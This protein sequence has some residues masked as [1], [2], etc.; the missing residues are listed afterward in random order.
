MLF[1]Q[2]AY[3][4][5]EDKIRTIVKKIYGG[6]GVIFFAK[7]R[8]Q[9]ELTANIDLSQFGGALPADEFYYVAE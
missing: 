7:A 4:Y 8:E 2:A 9:I 1:E 3:L 6:K 5:I